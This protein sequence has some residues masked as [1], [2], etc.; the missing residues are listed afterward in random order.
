MDV[1][2]KSL[3]LLPKPSPSDEWKLIIM[4]KNNAGTTQTQRCHQLEVA[5]APTVLIKVKRLSHLHA[6]RER[7]T[8]KEVPAT[9]LTPSSLTEFVAVHM[10][11]PNVF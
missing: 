8:K 9:K 1:S 10:D 3:G 6:L 11:K 4:F 7:R 5:G 2:P